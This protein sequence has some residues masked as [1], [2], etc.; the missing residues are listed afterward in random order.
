MAILHRTRTLPALMPRYAERFRCAGPSCEDTCCAGWPV[1]IDKKTYKAYRNQD[2]PALQPMMARMQRLDNSTD[3]REYAVLPIS[4]P[5]GACPAHQDGLCSVHANLGESFLNDTCQNYPRI[6]RNVNGQQEQVLSLSCIEAARTALLAEDAFE[7]VEAPVSIRAGTVHNTV[8]GGRMP[9]E[10]M[11]EAR[12]FCMNLVRTRELPLWQRLALLGAFCEALEGYRTGG[13]DPEAAYAI[14]SDFIRLIES[15][16]ALAP[17]DL[18]EP[19]FASQA[20]V[21]ATLWGA[22]GFKAS[23]IHQQDLMQRIAG[24]LGADASGQVSAAGLEAAYRRGLQ[25]LD[26]TISL[27]P[28]LLENYLLNEMFTNLFPIDADNPY[29]AYLQ[30]I[31]RFGMLRF[32]LAAQCNAEAELPQLTTLSATVALQCRRFQHDPQYTARVNQSLRESGW[33]DMNKLYTLIR[34]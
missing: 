25:R 24:G 22:S 34:T 16:E 8:V 26:Q 19:D 33:G 7:F 9:A 20:Q 31:A 3:V 30:L 21:F 6:N 5:Y 32:L 2:H 10:L 27:T 11:I 29:G 23:S 28:W 12:I 13:Q 15:G 14:I 18:I 1:H 4:G 17:L